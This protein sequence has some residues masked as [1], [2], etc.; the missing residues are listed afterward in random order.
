MNAA[1]KMNWSP[2]PQCVKRAIPAPCLLYP[3]EPTSPNHTGT[4]E[5]GRFCCKSRFALVIKNS[6]GRR[7]GFRVKM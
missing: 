3:D 2:L 7:R 1:L 6:A 5:S 4:S